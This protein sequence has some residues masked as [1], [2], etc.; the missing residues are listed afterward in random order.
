M[1]RLNADEMKAIELDMLKDIS[2]F[3]DN[4]GIR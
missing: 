2:N 4:N 1:K 3:C